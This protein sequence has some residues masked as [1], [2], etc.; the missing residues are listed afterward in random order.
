MVSEVIVCQGKLISEFRAIA[1]F[2]EKNKIKF[3][4]LIVCVKLTEFY[5]VRNQYFD[6]KHELVDV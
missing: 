5:K 6:K 4:Y 1:C 2:F 3:L